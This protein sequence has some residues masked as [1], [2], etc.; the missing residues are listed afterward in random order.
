MAC[1]L[2]FL[3]LPETSFLLEEISLITFKNRMVNMNN[4]HT[5]EYKEANILGSIVKIRPRRRQGPNPLIEGVKKFQDELRKFQE[6]Q[7][8]S[9]KISQK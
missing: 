2:L 6:Q 5:S 7:Q 3:F 8:Q 1:C 9:L 4:L